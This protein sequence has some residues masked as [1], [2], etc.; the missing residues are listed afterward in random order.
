MYWILLLGLALAWGLQTFLIH[1]MWR[2][3]LTVRLQFCERYIYEGDSSVLQEVVINDKWLPLPALEVRIAM[4]RHLAFTGEASDNS[5][6]SDQT[7]KRDVFSFLFHQQVT[8]SLSFTGKKR[9]C[10]E[11]K[12]ADLKA[13]DFFFRTL[14]YGVI[15]QDTMLYVYPAQ[16][17]TRRLDIITTAISGTILVQ[18]QLFPDPF[19]FA[20]IREYQPTDPMN[21]MNW[22][23]EALVEETIRIVSSLAARLV[24]ARMPVELYGNAAV[25]PE[26]K[27]LFA[28]HLPANASHIAKLNQQLACIGGYTMPCTELLESFDSTANT[29]QMMVFISKNTDDEIVQKIGSLASAA[30][31]V[32]WVIP[33]SPYTEQPAI[34]LPFVRTLFWEVEL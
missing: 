27:G 25:V 9:G 17:D 19:E 11:I 22:K 8:R 21:R 31:P 30:S 26:K 13:Y 5:G 18:N 1:H 24:A 10:Y 7:Y 34:T 29:E 23:A 20:G 12:Q 32:L 4:S 33:K 2:R 28:M 14:D 6:V 16:V 15:S 3:G